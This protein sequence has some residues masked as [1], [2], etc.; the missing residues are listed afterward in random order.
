[1]VAEKYVVN[2][3]KKST[4]LILNGTQAIAMKRVAK[5]L[6]IAWMDMFQ[7][8]CK[9]C[10]NKPKHDTE[11]ERY[12]NGNGSD[13][14]DECDRGVFSS[15]TPGFGCSHHF[16]MSMF[17][18]YDRLAEVGRDNAIKDTRVL[19]KRVLSFNELEMQDHIVSTIKLHDGDMDDPEVAKS[20][21]KNKMHEK[22][23]AAVKRA[24]L[25]WQVAMLKKIKI[26]APETFSEAIEKVEGPAKKDTKP[27]K[28][29]KKPRKESASTFISAKDNKVKKVVP[30]TK[31]VERRKSIQ[32]ASKVEKSPF[33]SKATVKKG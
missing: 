25:R 2:K 6:G 3:E 9:D 27:S 12:F 23:E 19:A 20:I 21:V 30:T 16:G 17:G 15:H 4:T 10:F 8:D 29:V 22:K 32:K 14:E 24:I 26:V 11:L 33:T 7:Y 31:S 1:M 5:R 18:G 28:V 13:E